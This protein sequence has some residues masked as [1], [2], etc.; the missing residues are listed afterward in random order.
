MCNCVL[1][2][3]VFGSRGAKVKGGWGS[4]G[5][6]TPLTFERGVE[7][8]LISKE[9]WRTNFKNWTFLRKILKSIGLF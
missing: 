9:N 2:D 1:S 7:P 3:N 4:W 5:V 8:P 6:A